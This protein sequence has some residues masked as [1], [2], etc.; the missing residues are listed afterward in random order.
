MAANGMLGIYN[1]RPLT[2]S[3]DILNAITGI[4][5]RI[6]E[7]NSDIFRHIQGLPVVSDSALR[8]TWNMGIFRALHW[9]RPDQTSNCER[10]RLGLPSW[11]WTG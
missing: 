1:R 2:Y 8:E 7:R 10:R 9:C 4:L 3:G 11:S 6:Q 5:N